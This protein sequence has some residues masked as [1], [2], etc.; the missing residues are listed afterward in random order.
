MIFEVHGVK[1][2]IDW[3]HDRAKHKNGRGTYVK[4]TTIILSVISASNEKQ[5]SHSTTVRRWQSEDPHSPEKARKYSM[6]KLT[7]E[8]FG[9]N[10]RAEPAIQFKR[11]MW[12]A[13]FNRPKGVIKNE[14]TNSPLQAGKIEL[15]SRDKRSAE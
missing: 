3:R 11:A 15:L 10:G 2:H 14:K 4:S 1:H 8:L 9:Q 5:I 12:E 13:Y 6:E 7:R